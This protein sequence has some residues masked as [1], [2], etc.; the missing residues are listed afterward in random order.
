L[1]ALRRNRSPHSSTGLASADSDA[2]GPG[3]LVRRSPDN[4]TATVASACTPTVG[5]M[6]TGFIKPPSASR[7]PLSMTGVKTPGIAIDALI[8]AAIGPLWNHTS[9][10]ASR[11]AATAV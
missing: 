2:G 10:R 4:D 7:R 11:S 8:A 1:A 6:G 9:R 3:S 5:A